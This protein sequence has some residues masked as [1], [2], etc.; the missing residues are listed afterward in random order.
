MLNLVIKWVQV[1][2]LTK[3]IQSTSS[4]DN[5]VGDPSSTEH[6]QEVCTRGRKPLRM[7]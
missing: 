3:T 7:Q 6:P 5:R 4:E 2:K 1:V